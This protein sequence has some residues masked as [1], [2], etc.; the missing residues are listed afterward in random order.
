MIDFMGSRATIVP[1]ALCSGTAEYAAIMAAYVVNLAGP[2]NTAQGQVDAVQFPFWFKDPPAYSKPGLSKPDC[3]Y[4]G[5]ATM[6]RETAIYLVQESLFVV[7][8]KA[9]GYKALGAEAGKYDCVTAQLMVM[10]A[11]LALGKG[12]GD[13]KTYPLDAPMFTYYMTESDKFQSL[14]KG[15]LQAAL[16]A[17]K[18][19]GITWLDNAGKGYVPPPET[20]LG[21]VFVPAPE[22]SN[23]APLAAPPKKDGAG[24]GTGTTATGDTT[25]QPASWMTRHPWVVPTALVAAGAGGIG[26]WMWHRSRKAA[27]QQTAPAA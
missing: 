19:Q 1:S 5:L 27:E 21:S 10:G 9:W 6:S 4:F 14:V 13:V 22:P 15:A 24:A 3:A 2:T 20:A 11:E 17:A 18:Q 12:V 7:L 23:C 26:I 25:G 8:Q 16:P